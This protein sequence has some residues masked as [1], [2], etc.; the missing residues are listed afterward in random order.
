MDFDINLILV[1]VTLVFLLIWLVDKFVLKQ[2]RAVKSYHT[3]IKQAEDAHEKQ[4][5]RMN[6]A[7]ASHQITANAE[8]YIPNETTPAAVQSAHQDFVA[9]RVRLASLKGNPPS[10]STLVRWAYEFLPVLAVI[11]IVRSFI[12]EPFNI[13]S[14]SMVPTL[15]TGDFIAVNKSAYGLRLPITHTKIL[16]TG[17]P[18]RGDVAVFRYP[19]NDKVYFI[20]RVIGLPG[21]TVSFDKGVLSINGER[22]NTTP[23]QY[24]MPQP[25]VDQMY[26]SVI[27]QQPISDT[28]RAALG[29]EEE[30]YARYQ[31]E[32][33]GE[34]TYLARYV[35]E[36]G[37]HPD[38][39]LVLQSPETSVGG[40]QWRVT[41]PEGHYFV[42]GDNRDRSQ[43]GR[44]W[45][46]VPEANLSGKA[47]YI[48]MHKEPGLNLPTFSR[49]G[50]ID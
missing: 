41:V 20:K 28:D 15:Y 19:V 14:S 40:S 22:V 10:E 36:Q 33:L 39:A 17:S 7:L 48:W 50:A 11:V 1:P 38:E 49:N 43:D 9:S 25:L 35:G 29:R 21:D 6:A 31:T 26:P 12:V 42:L 5:M 47:T 44:F 45:G 3:D 8:A 18:E 16:D 13:P 27:N 46:F 34:H 4:R 23:A 30:R 2:H 24:D 32:Q 37:I